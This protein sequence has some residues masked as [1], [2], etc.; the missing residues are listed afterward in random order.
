MTR[1]GTVTTRRPDR[2]PSSTV[3]ELLRSTGLER[4]LTVC[5]GLPGALVTRPA[6]AGAGSREG[7]D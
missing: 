3:V 4:Y 6:P 1:A 5:P 2:P 7:T